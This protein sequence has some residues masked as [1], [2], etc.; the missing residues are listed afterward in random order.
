MQNLVNDFRH[1][2]LFDLEQIGTILYR[3]SANKIEVSMRQ[4]SFIWN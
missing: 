4:R 2:I 3:R 1:I